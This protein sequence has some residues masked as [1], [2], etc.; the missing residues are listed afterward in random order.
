MSYP[1]FA[2]DVRPL[3]T[4]EQEAISH[5]PPVEDALKQEF[6]QTKLGARR[7][8]IEKNATD[9]ETEVGTE[10]AP[11]ARPYIE[12]L[13]LKKRDRRVIELEL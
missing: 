1:G 8:Y 3:S 9:L 10:K 12:F 4:A 2:D 11:G 7:S 13:D 6:G 5:L